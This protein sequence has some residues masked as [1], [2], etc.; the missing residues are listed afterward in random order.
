MRF[1][2]PIAQSNNAMYLSIVTSQ[3]RAIPIMPRLF[4]KLLTKIEV[5]PGA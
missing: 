4:T 3:N 5:L 2:Y 1:S